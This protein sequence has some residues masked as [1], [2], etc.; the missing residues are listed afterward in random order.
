MNVIDA[1]LYFTT[2]SYF[3]AATL[4]RP[5]TRNVKPRILERLLM[6]FLG[7]A[8]LVNLL[9]NLSILWVFYAVLWALAA[10]MSY[11]GYIQW[12]ILWRDTVSDEA[13][14]T[15]FL[16]DALIAFCCLLKL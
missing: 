5:L 14:I 13:Q 7:A 10:G 12:N 8:L 15:M 16:W 6:A 1:F 3:L 11:L 4:P 9:L 2:V